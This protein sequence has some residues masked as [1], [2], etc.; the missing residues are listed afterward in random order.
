MRLAGGNDGLQFEAPGELAA[1][2]ALQRSWKEDTM[3]FGSHDGKCCC[4]GCTG[5]SVLDDGTSS[6]GDLAGLMLGLKMQAPLQGSTKGAFQQPMLASGNVPTNL[7]GALTRVT[8]SAN[9]RSWTST[10]NESN[11]DGNGINSTL[12]NSVGVKL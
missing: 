6:M 5:E 4:P 1:A 12:P 11:G 3:P 2:A 7:A 9:E 10:A 8:S